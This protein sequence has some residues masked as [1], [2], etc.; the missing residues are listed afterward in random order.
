MRK[1][2]LLALTVVCLMVAAASDEDRSHAAGFFMFLD[3]CH[4]STSDLVFGWPYSDANDVPWV[5]PAGEQWVDLSLFNNGWRDGTYLSMG[6]LPG[7][8]QEITWSG[9][10]VE[11][12]HYLRVTKRLG[13]RWTATITLPHTPCACLNGCVEPPVDC[14]IKGNISLSTGEKIYHFPDSQFYDAT[15]IDPSRGER[16]F[17]TEKGAR[18]NGWRPSLAR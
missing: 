8:L 10:A 17:C 1:V 18:D 5:D 2:G 14:R 16:W 9:L 15:V 12:T 3:K 7:T 13:D 4:G 11:K 6:P